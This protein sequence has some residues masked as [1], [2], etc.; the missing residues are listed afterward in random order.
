MSGGAAPWSAGAP[1]CIATAS[2]VTSCTYAGSCTRP[3]LGPGSE[4]STQH[5][6]SG[7]VRTAVRRERRVDLEPGQPEEANA[8]VEA[9]ADL[10]A[11]F[12]REL[13][14]RLELPGA[15]DAGVLVLVVGRPL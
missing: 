13:V 2:L 10:D 11:A 5:G 8:R 4:R 3:F 15:D 7:P 9:A 1:S 14:R 12:G 6:S